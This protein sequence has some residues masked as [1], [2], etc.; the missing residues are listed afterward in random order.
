MRTSISRSAAAA[1]ALRTRSARSAMTYATR[2]KTISVNTRRGSATARLNV[3]SV[4]KKSI[5]PTLSTAAKVDA[6][7]PHRSA[8]TTTPRM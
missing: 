1:A 2:R 7:R 8:M 3:G 6:T 5:A 4:K